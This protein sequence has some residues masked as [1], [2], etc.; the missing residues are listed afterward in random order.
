[1]KLSHFIYA[2]L[3]LMAVTMLTTL[4]LAYTADCQQQI[5]AILGGGLGMFAFELFMLIVG[6][7]II[8]ASNW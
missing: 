8:D 7:M 6:G 3:G 4:G 2:V 5:N 1:M